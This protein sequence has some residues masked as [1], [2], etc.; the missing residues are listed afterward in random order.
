[1]STTAYEIHKTN[2]A[3]LRTEVGTVCE[4]LWDANPNHAQQAKN[5]KYHLLVS[6]MD[7]HTS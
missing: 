4:M 1:M 6:I 2:N 5:K 7:S 3:T